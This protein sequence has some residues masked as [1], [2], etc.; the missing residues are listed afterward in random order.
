MVKQQL[1]KFDLDTV[2]DGYYLQS[3][4]DIYPNL[5]VRLF[6][7]KNRPLELYFAGV[8]EFNE[9][10]TR[11][12]TLELTELDASDWLDDFAANKPDHTEEYDISKARFLRLNLKDRSFEILVDGYT[13]ESG[14]SEKLT[15]YE[16]ITSLL[17]L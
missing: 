10:L 5:Y 2:L 11:N 16:H 8:L 17:S 6:D 9:Q 7:G 1:E 12:E 13:S 4:E 3:T 14:H 15:R